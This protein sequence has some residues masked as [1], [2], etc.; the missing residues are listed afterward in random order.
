MRAVVQRVTSASVDSE[1][2]RSGAVGKGFCVLLGV[3]CDDTE[4]DA[5]WLAEKIVNLRVFDDETG[6]M[7]RSLA[8]VGGQM[9]V[10]SQFTLYGDCRRGRRPSFSAAARPDRAQELYRRFVEDVGAL[11]I[12]VETGVFRTMMTVNIVN[13]GPVTLIIDTWE[14]KS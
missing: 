7:N 9:L 6:K 10:V 5:A 4:E 1:G 8:D 3:A 12:H 2:V 13:D 14:R 11:G